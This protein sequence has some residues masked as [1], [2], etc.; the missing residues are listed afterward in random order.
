MYKFKGRIGEPGSQSPEPLVMT[1]GEGG[2][3]CPATADSYFGY[4]SSALGL[5]F[6]MALEHG[7][8]A[9]FFRNYTVADGD[10]GDDQV[11]AIVELVGDALE[12]RGLWATRDTEGAEIA[13]ELA[14]E[15]REAQKKSSAKEL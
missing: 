3:S 12:R 10:K 8:F 4:L 1:D 7:P 9:D 6:K 14:Q 5:D 2:K 13:E 11:D 15:A